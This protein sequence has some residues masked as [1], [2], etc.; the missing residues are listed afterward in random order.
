MAN[1]SYNTVRDLEK[2]NKKWFKTAGIIGGVG[3][4]CVFLGALL[5]ALIVVGI[6][7]II[8]CAVL[9]LIGMIRVIHLSKEPMRSIYCPY[10]ASKNDVF[11]TKREIPC[12]ICG[13]RIGIAI[14]GEVT[15]LE[16]IEDDED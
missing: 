8:I 3:L 11:L 15:P 14:S 9:L 6:A 7:A 16:P 12:D 4:V 1:T 5:Q 10:C 13:R 2:S